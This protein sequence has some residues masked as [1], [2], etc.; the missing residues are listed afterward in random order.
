MIKMSFKLTTENQNQIKAYLQN[1]LLK[2]AEQLKECV[3]RELKDFLDSYTPKKYIRKN[4]LR[5][6]LDFNV[7]VNSNAMTII[8]YFNDL[9]T[10]TSMFSR[11]KGKTVNTAYLLNYGYQVK[12]ARFKDVEFFG[13]RDTSGYSAYNFVEQGIKNF[14]QSNQWGV[15]F[16]IDL[17]VIKPSTGY[18]VK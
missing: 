6:S 15:Q 9:A 10:D 7:V 16:P 12:N 8:V 3:Q 17:V 14:N 2:V 11:S 18:L 5:N 4:R 1:E 13:F